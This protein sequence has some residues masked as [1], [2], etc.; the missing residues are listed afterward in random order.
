M[1]HLKP[2]A[3]NRLVDRKT[4][5]L[6]EFLSEV[7]NSFYFVLFDPIDD[8]PYAELYEIFDRWYR[9]RAEW[10]NNMR[11]GKKI[12]TASEDYFENMFKPVEVPR[13]GGVFIGLNRLFNGWKIL[14]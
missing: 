11:K 10:H 2:R 13:S 3:V 4:T 8:S 1:K 14:I 6:Q 9:G 5:E 12:V 7:E